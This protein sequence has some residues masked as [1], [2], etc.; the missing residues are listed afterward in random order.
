L[1]L[2]LKGVHAREARLAT[3]ET[4]IYYRHRSTGLNLGSSLDEASVIEKFKALEAI[5]EPIR[6]RSPGTF[7]AAIAEFKASREWADKAPTTRATW[8]RVF[9]VLEELF[10]PYPMASIK[11]AAAAAA[12]NRLIAAHGGE[13]G[14]THIAVARAVWSWCE[15]TGRTELVNPFL[16]LG[17]FTTKDQRRLKREKK[18]SAIWNEA[19]IKALLNAYRKINAGGN[20]NL[21]RGEQHFREERTPPDIRMAVLLGFYTFQRQTDILDL[22]ARSIVLRDGEYWWQLNQNKTDTFLG[23]LLHP[24]LV[25]EIKE[26]GIKPGSA[27]LLV[28]APVSGERFNRR[29]FARRWKLWTAAANIQL[30]FSA[31]RRSGMIAMAEKG[32]ESEQ[33]AAVSG[34]SIWP[35]PVNSPVWN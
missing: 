32:I 23:I 2:K 30:P 34:H 24:D 7:A 9:P 17:G 3:G 26:Q 5:K 8:T 27:R 1:V 29:V 35:E 18:R 20:P 25:K 19:D 12:K 10:G 31:L 13:G 14:K 28:M 4:R 15:Q 33:I 21:T 16:R 11:R 6:V 22:T